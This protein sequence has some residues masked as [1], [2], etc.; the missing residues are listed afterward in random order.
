MAFPKTANIRGFPGISKDF[1]GSYASLM[2]RVSNQDTPSG[3]VYGANLM[4]MMT[5]NSVITGNGN[6]I[7]A[8]MPG[9]SSSPIYMSWPIMSS[10]AWPQRVTRYLLHH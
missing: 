4:G 7:L 3:L 5:H 9:G 2:S 8:L 10:P 6:E 1:Q